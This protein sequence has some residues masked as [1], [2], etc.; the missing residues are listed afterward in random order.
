MLNFREK[1]I[2][3]KF[4][5]TD[6]FDQHSPDKVKLACSFGK[7]SMV[8]LHLVLGIFPKIQVF[9]VLTPMKPTETSK[10]KDK[11]ELLWGLNL[12]VFQSEWEPIDKLWEEDPD[13]CC[14]I[15]KVKPT[16]DALLWVDC[17]ITGLR[18][19]EGGVRKDYQEVEHSESITKVNPILQWTEREVW[20]YLA[21]HEIPVHPFYKLGYR[22]LGCE[23]CTAIVGA[24]VEERDGRWQHTRKKA[25]ECG[26]HTME[27]K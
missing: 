9:T 27:M 17:W 7:D 4:L 6:I 10:Y 12:E 5:I 24:D 15:F 3:S 13:L 1:I 22:S 20:Q 11:I 8:V 16:K 2:H 23:P 19:T 25:G 18:N 14:Q 21:T 26:I